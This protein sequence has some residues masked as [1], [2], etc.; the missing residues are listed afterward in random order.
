MFIKNPSTATTEE[1]LKHNEYV[2]AMKKLAR[3]EYANKI[4]EIPDAIA[5][6]KTCLYDGVDRCEHCEDSDFA[7]YNIADYV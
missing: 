5:P 4:R 2:R 6:C 7:G 3:Q 1:I